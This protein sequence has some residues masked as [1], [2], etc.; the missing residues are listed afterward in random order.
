VATVVSNIGSWMYSAAA[1]WLMTRLDSGPVMVSLVQVASTLPVFLF[2]LPAGALADTVDKRRFL[3]GAESFITIIST[4]FAA[5]VWARLITPG[6]LLLFV[7]L[8]EAGGAVTAPAWQSIISMLVPKDDL[9]AAVSMNGVGVNISRAVGP[10]LGGLMTARVGIAAPFWVNAISNL[11]TVGALVWWRP[12]REGT[13]QL[14]A[15]HFVSAMRTGLRYA[16]NNRDLQVTLVRVAAFFLTASCYWALLPLVARNQLHGGA[17]LYGVLL[18]AIGASAIVGAFALPWLRAHLSANA[19]VAVGSLGTAL[20]LALFGAARIPAVALAASLVAGVSWIAVLAT[21]NVSAQ[22]ALPAWVRG[23]GLAVY[24]TVFFGALTLGGVVWGQVAHAASVPVALFIAAAVAV[25]AIPVTWSWKLQS[26][27]SRDLTPSMHWPTPL[28]GEPVDEDA[29][30]VLVTVAYAV[31]A[32]DR[33]AFL[34]AVE[35][36]SYERGRDGAY[37]WGIFEDVA[38]PGRFLE[39][40]LV[41]SW[42]EHLR[43]HERVTNAD[44]V[45]QEQISG[46]VIGAPTVTHF[47]APRAGR[48]T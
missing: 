35:R 47:V 17:T 43:Q 9:P 32:S 16:R 27:A 14:P 29:G 26:G 39:T 36:L 10:A 45:L 15:E 23:R 42:L 8:I 6:T 30:P 18:G 33:A 34:D 28:V 5:L 12:P 19:L 13:S 1:A 7:F 31:R 24:V 37:S 11:G 20:T 38:A 41:D 21:L 44:R 25:V 40:F 2:A 48:G 4:V 3:I 46:I 22:L